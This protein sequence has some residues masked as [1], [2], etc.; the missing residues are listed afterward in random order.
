MKNITKLV[1]LCLLLMCFAFISVPSKKRI[2]IDAGHGGQDHGVSH[3]DLTEKQLVQNIATK[4]KALDITNEIE[5]ILLREDDSFLS[6]HERV[7]KINDLNADLLI[8]LHINYSLDRNE[9]GISAYVSSTNKFYES[10]R[11]KAETLVNEIAGQNL[12]KKEIKNA[13]LFVLNNTNCAGLLL[14][15]GYMTNE[16][17]R[18]YISSEIGQEEIAGR[19]FGSLGE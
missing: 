16:K 19:I 5:I 10:S 8:S 7:I 2:I 6:L 14:E 3:D 9:N 13:N 12:T 15:L 1:G 17:D 4:I 18:N 11:Q